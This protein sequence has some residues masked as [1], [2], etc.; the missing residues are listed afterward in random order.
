M[1]IWPHNLRVDV[2]RARALRIPL[3]EDSQII[4]YHKFHE[5]QTWLE[6]MFCYALK[7]LVHYFVMLYFFWRIRNLIASGTVRFFVFEAVKATRFSA[8]SGQRFQ[9]ISVVRMREALLVQYR[10]L[11]H[12]SF[13]VMGS[14]LPASRDV[15]QHQP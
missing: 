6:S 11:I 1:K 7:L 9:D 14:T 5:S 8:G 10:E 15:A 13:P 4:N 3:K 12:G 2:S